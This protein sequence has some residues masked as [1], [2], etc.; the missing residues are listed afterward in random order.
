MALVQRALME[1][2]SIALKSA[3]GVWRSD[4]FAASSLAAIM[5]MVVMWLRF[6]DGAGAV[7]EFSVLLFPPGVTALDAFAAASRLN[8]DIVAQGPVEFVLVVA[9]RDGDLLKTASTVG[10]VL[11]LNAEFASLCGGVS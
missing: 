9:P 5:L 4:Y 8:V 11:V 7:G 2:A 6:V 1:K 3:L 10:A